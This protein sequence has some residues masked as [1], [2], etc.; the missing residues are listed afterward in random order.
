MHSSM[1]KTYMRRMDPSFSEKALGYH[2]F[3][4]FLLDHEEIVEMEESGH[5]RRV[6]PREQE[7]EQASSGRS[8]RRSRKS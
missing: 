8:G 7:K 6:R 2:S 1:V 4:E 3:S 5:S